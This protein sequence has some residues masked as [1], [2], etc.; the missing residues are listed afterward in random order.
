MFVLHILASLAAVDVDVDVVDDVDVDVDADTDSAVVE[1]V[2]A[3]AVVVAVVVVY[4][5]VD[6]TVVLSAAVVLFVECCDVW[7]DNTVWP[8]FNLFLLLF[9]VVVRGGVYFTHKNI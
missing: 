5:C 3:V 8:D 4:L 9:V 7:L 6:Y 2:H 1:N